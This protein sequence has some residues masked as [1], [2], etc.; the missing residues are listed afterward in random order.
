MTTTLTP[1]PVDVTRELYGARLPSW[2]P[3]VV[4]AAGVVA[5]GGS[6]A[7]GANALQA[8]LLAWVVCM[9]LDLQKLGRPDKS[10]QD[11]LP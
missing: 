11:F 9:W 2:G 6:Y 10:H 8:A 4:V 1:P 7:A 3:Q 5:A